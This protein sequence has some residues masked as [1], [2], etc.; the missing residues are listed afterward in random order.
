[1]TLIVLAILVS[2]NTMV[3]H[4]AYAAEP[5]TRSGSFEYSSVLVFDRSKEARQTA[6]PVPEYLHVLLSLGTR[7]HRYDPVRKSDESHI[8]SFSEYSHYGNIFFDYQMFSSVHL[9]GSWALEKQKIKRYDGV[10][11]SNDEP[12][13]SERH[14]GI[15][16]DNDPFFMSYQV[17]E[18]EFPLL[19]I[20][21]TD[22]F[23]RE[24]MKVNVQIG[25]AGF[26]RKLDNGISLS[27]SVDYTKF[28]KYESPVL[29]TMEGDSIS[30]NIWFLHSSGFGLRLKEEQ[31]QISSDSY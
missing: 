21:D 11:V 23:V 22:A 26:R 14:V 8:S 16:L 5:T 19:Y 3:S 12:S 7:F 6:I 2:V 1:M 24:K 13:A 17:G 18:W 9:I 10:P 28:E 25:T 20:N 29:G 4:T 15:Q 31:G 30:A 27:F